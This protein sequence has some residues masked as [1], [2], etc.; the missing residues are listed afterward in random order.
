[1]NEETLIAPCP[2]CGEAAL[3]RSGDQFSCSSCGTEVAQRRF[4]AIRLGDRFIFRN[5]GPDYRNAETDLVGRSFTKAELAELS[6]TCYK[7]SDLEAIASGDLSSLR[8]PDSAVAQVIFSHSRETCLLQVNALRRANGPAI[9]DGVRRLDHP[10]DNHGL[11]LLDQGNLFIS[12][13]RL[14]FPSDTHTAIRI[15]RKLVG[16]C[17]F[18]NAV[19][20]QRDGE[21]TATYFL[22]FQSRTALLVAAFFQGRLEHLR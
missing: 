10:R 16:V 6:G 22:G 9:S 20:V 17:A 21:N 1:M 19:A 14:I 13:Q 12:E 18:S 4:L 3:L 11:E 7:D 5:I 2:I 8:P 15:D